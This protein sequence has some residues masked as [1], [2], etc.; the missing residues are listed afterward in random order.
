MASSQILDSL[1]G[2]KVTVTCLDRKEVVLQGEMMEAT[3]LGVAI[4]TLDHG[5]EFIEFVPFQN[6]GLISHKILGK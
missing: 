2:E 6:I 5:R 1:N 4:K 3:E